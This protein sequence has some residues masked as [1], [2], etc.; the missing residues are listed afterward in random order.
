MYQ[1]VILYT[2]GTIHYV[3]ICYSIIVYTYITT[4][5]GVLEKL[6]TGYWHGFFRHMSLTSDT[7]GLVPN[8]MSKRSAIASRKIAT[9]GTVTS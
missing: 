2:Y 7:T 3:S 4:V 8:S 5:N 1:Y 9:R 6:I